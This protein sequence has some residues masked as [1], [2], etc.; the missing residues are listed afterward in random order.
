MLGLLSARPDKHT[1]HFYQEGLANENTSSAD[2]DS[3][4]IIHMD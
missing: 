3:N 1:Q 4:V 2:V